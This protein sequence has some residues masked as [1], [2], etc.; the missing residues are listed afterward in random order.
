MYIN[1][2]NLRRSGQQP[3]MFH[4]KQYIKHL[5]L[6]VIVWARWW[7]PETVAEILLV[8]SFHIVSAAH[9]EKQ[10]TQKGTL[11]LISSETIQLTWT[12]SIDMEIIT[13][14][15]T[16]GGD[17]FF[18][19]NLKWKFCN[20]AFFYPLQWNEEHWRTKS[21]SIFGLLLVKW[22]DVNKTSLLCE[23]RCKLSSRKNRYYWLLSQNKP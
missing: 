17:N 18:V 5:I 16:F 22:E 2:N 15:C 6:I 10:S 20:A 12:E 3:K 7:W 11:K 19:F 4:M 23:K 1:L 8:M 14:F 13:S 21:L 9:I